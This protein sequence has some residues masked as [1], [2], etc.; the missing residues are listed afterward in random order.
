VAAAEVRGL[1]VAAMLALGLA[2]CG[3]SDEP[4]KELLPGTLTVGAVVVSAR[5]RVIARGARIDVGE[6]NAVGGIAGKVPVR[7]VTA[8]DAGALVRRGAKAVLLP[9]EAAE[10]AQAESTLR[11]RNVFMLATCNSLAPT[12]AWGAGPSLA[13][14]ID[15]L[16]STL[17]ERHVPRVAVLP[18]PN[19]A[20]LTKAAGAW[21]IANE[22][23]AGS[24][25]AGSGWRWI[26]NGRLVYG[27]DPLDSARRIAA[28]GQAAEG[29]T[30]ATF[31]YPVPGSELDELYE[32]YR[33][34]YGARPDGSEVQLGYN[35]LRVID[36]AVQQ[37]KSTDPKEMAANLP[38][39]SIGGAGGSLDYLEDGSRQPRA[40]VAVVQVRGGRLELVAR[41]RPERP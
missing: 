16:M 23:T 34:D 18:G 21:G 24:A 27:L 19:A 14:R 31:G 28:A 30:F 9:C 8:P 10:Q 12:R 7:F 5:D 25:V 41:G 32:K 38:G 35:A 13:D 22:P 3:G 39:L 26:P 36:K 40:D 1:A 6:I 2:A 15:G 17:H 29:V 4:K 20:Q 33:L 37:A 11:G